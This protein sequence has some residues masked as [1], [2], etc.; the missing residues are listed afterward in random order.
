MLVRPEF[1]PATSRS[2]DRR[3]SNWA[4]WAAVRKTIKLLKRSRQGCCIHENNRTTC[5]WNVQRLNTLREL[6]K[7]R[8]TFCVNVLH[9]LPWPFYDKGTQNN[10]FK[11]FPFPPGRDTEERGREMH[12]L[13]WSLVCSSRKT[14]GEES[15][16][17]TSTFR[18]AFL[19]DELV[20]MIQKQTDH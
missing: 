1:E 18:G 2:A 14:S 6:W 10:L 17:S 3:L 12:L 16:T 11:R 13:V 5:E 4:T 8:S 7:N 15:E 9:T 20:F 19:W